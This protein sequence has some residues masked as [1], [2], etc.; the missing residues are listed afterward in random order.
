M[1]IFERPCERL[2][3][4]RYAEK[5][6]DFKVNIARTCRFAKQRDTYLGTHVRVP[7]A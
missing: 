4:H 1:V 2:H 5:D 7:R 3:C 6:F